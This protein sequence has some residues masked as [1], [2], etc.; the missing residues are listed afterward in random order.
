ME[1]WQIVRLVEC[2]KA[3]KIRFELFAVLE[4]AGYKL[5]YQLTQR[6]AVVKFLDDDARKALIDKWLFTSVAGYKDDEGLV[7]MV[8]SDYQ[9]IEVLEE[10]VT[11]ANGQF[12]ASNCGKDILR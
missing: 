11:R 6:G 12:I 10:L 9:P 4:E 2:L 8:L 1:K 5:V 7:L 3:T